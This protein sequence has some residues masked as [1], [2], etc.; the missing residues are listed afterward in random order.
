MLPALDP[1]VHRVPQ[2]KPTCLFITLEATLTKTFRFCSSPATTQT[3]RQP[4]P[5]I[6]G[7]ESVHT[8]LSTTHHECIGDTPLK[9]YEIHTH[10]TTLHKVSNHPVNHPSYINQGHG[11]ALCSCSWSWRTCNTLPTKAAPPSPFVGASTHTHITL[12]TLSSSLCVKGLTRGWYG[13]WTKAYKLAPP[14]LN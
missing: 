10:N 11:F 12:L 7:Q 8:M 14:L 9:Q 5:A 3:K 1:P 4:T 13:W 2:T 6:P